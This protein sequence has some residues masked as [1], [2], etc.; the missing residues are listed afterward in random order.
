MQHL[1]GDDHL[2]HEQARPLLRHVRQ[3]SHAE[4]ENCFKCHRCVFI[5]IIVLLLTSDFKCHRYYCVFIAEKKRKK[6]LHI[7]F[8]FFVLLLKI[9]RKKIVFIMK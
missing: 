7:A 9:K 4:K 5:I 3:S 8:N 6:R 1:Q 2:R